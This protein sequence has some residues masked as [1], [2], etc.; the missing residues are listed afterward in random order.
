[1]NDQYPYTTVR[2]QYSSQNLHIQDQENQQGRVGEV[3][4]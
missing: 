2:A 4:E 1:M 3:D